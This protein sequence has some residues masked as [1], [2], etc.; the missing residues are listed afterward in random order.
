M[1]RDPVIPVLLPR[2]YAI[3]A[4]A[5]GGLSEHWRRFERH[6]DVDSFEPDRVESERLNR[7]APGNLRWHARGLARTTGK[8]KLY[9]LNRSTGSSLYPPNEAVISRYSAKS[10]WGLKETVDVDCTSLDDFLT[11]RGTATPHLLKLDTQGSELDIMRGLSDARWATVLGAEIEVE[12]LDLYKGQP[13]FHDVHRFMTERGFELF[14]LRTHRAYRAHEDSEDFFLRRFWPFDGA[15]EQVTAQL[16]A[17]DALYL[18]PL[19][20]LRNRESLLRFVLVTLIYHC[21]ELSLLA[22]DRLER[23][24]YASADEAES[25]RRFI[26]SMGPKP[27]LFDRQDRIGSAARL[28]GRALGRRRERRVF[29]TERVL[30]D[31]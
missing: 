16:V 28:I 31:Q 7:N 9:I 15:R 2:V 26:V 21:Y 20:A 19:D 10:Y 18:R 6:L 12:F 4:G 3:D 27:G 23:E 24:G 14:D 25:L 29:W 17:G 1:G 13:L 22:V 11:G 30:P 8:H 5:H